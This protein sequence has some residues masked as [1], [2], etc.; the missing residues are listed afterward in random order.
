MKSLIPARSAGDYYSF[1]QL[2]HPDKSIRHPGPASAFPLTP[3][4]GFIARSQA[5][6]Y[7]IIILFSARL[8][9][10]LWRELAVSD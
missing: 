9:V 5:N 6:I 7:E 3:Y 10:D 1:Q 2:L 4:S 8:V